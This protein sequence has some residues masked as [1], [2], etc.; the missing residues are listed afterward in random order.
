ME[1]QAP[2]TA[3]EHRCEEA[4]PMSVDKY[5]PCNRPARQVVEADGK[6]LRMCEACAHHSK[7]NRGMKI[8]REYGTAADELVLPETGGNNPPDPIDEITAAYEAERDEA[9]NWT[10]GTPVENEAQMNEVDAL[11][12][13][14]RQWRLDLERGQKS[15][16]APLYDAY[17]AEQERWKPTIEDAK[18]IE[19]ALVATVDHF[20]RKLAEEKRAKERAAW[21]AAEKARR[22]AEE[23]ARAA[24]ESDLEAQREAA[25][26]KEAA[27]QAEKDA[28]A[29]KKDQVG[30]LRK[31]TKYEV[32]DYKA[33]LHWL[34]ANRKDDLTAFMD[35]W[36]RR[37]HKP[38]PQAD[39]LRVWQD[40]EAY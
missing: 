26:A 28:Q 18:R 8:V 32:T 33:L 34:A 11:R 24:A 5:M 25:A 23:K 21:E 13:A 19:K 37:N 10:D 27:M 31:V 7:H 20:K 35:E 22:E 36:A 4:S 15:A 1:D 14:M 39:G 3:G 6:E 38:D 16:T 17:K 40:R 29:A 30:G 2:I 9:A 12:K